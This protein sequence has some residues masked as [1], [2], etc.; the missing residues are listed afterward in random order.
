MYLALVLILPVLPLLVALATEDEASPA[1]LREYGY[2]EAFEKPFDIADRGAD[3][4]ARGGQ[5]GQP[6][7]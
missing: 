5:E 4:D 2:N 3:S 7:S 6:V 1:G